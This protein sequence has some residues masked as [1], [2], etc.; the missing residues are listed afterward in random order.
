M[1]FT[2]LMKIELNEDYLQEIQAAKDL[3]N[4]PEATYWNLFEKKCLKFFGNSMA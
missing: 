2:N 4:N 1:K 3:L